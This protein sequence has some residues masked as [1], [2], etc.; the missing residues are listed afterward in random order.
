MR[1]TTLAPAGFDA[2][3]SALSRSYR[4]RIST[5]EWGVEPAERRQVLSW[6]RPLDVA[7]MRDAAAALLGLHDFAAYCRPRLGATT[8][9]D[10]QRL[11]VSEHDVE[12]Q[13][14][15]T[16]DA[17]CHAMV[18]SLVGALL[19]VGDG[20]DARTAPAERLAA[21]E[22]TAAIAVAPAHGLTLVRV[23]YPPDDELAAR[24][25]RTRALRA[26]NAPGPPANTG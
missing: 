8:I 13:V 3:F 23:T 10:L 25:E 26:T 20:R 7:A 2:R 11:D 12:V 5:A 14:D 4:Y 22:R 18:R 1:S 17:F 19:A 16:A 6:R 9:R 24:A 15:V 21:R